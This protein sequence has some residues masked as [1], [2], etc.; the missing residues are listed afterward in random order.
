MMITSEG[1]TA[2]EYLPS[3]NCHSTHC[4]SGLINPS[5]FKGEGVLFYSGRNT[6]PQETDSRK[7][8]R[9]GNE[10]PVSVRGRLLPG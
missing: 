8:L 1:P 7:I 5:P 2:I 6:I 4:K 3:G 10:I 9:N